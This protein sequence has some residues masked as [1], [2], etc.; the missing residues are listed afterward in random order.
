LRGV[1]VFAN[2]DEGAYTHT[3]ESG[4]FEF[5]TPSG[6][7]EF[8]AFEWPGTHYRSTKRIKASSG[9]VAT[10]ARPLAVT[11]SA[12]DAHDGSAVELDRVEICEYV[13]DA[14]TGEMAPFG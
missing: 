1:R 2:R 8:L 6:Q 12:V 10:F 5:W 11:G 14:R 3:D 9:I 13:Q 4:H 7:V